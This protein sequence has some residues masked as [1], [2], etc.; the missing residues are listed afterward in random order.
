MFEKIKSILKH[1][2]ASGHWSKFIIPRAI[3]NNSDIIIVRWLNFYPI[4]KKK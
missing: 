2:H 1:K 3:V 4:C